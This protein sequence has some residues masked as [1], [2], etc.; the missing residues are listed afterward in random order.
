[1][2]RMPGLHRIP[3]AH[4]DSVVAGQ[5]MVNGFWVIVLR[6][7]LDIA[8]ADCAG[9]AL[10]A[11]TQAHQD[12]V[13]DV[14]RVTFAGSTFVNILLRAQRRARL[15]IAAP[16]RVVARVLRITGIDLVIPVHPTVE[17]AT[18]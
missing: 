11:A 1:M 4:D 7:E 9:E 14:S 5:Y 13:V 16:S 18:S 10:R 17:D 3:A 6:G 2:P 8:S 15:Q 12:V